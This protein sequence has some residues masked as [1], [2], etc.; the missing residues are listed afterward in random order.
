MSLEIDHVV[1]C[2]ADL[3]EAADRLEADYGLV[4]IE[5]GRHAGHGTANRIVPLG[6][7][8]LELVGVVDPEETRASSFGRWVAANASERLAPHALCLR[9]DDLDGLCDRF[10]LLPVAM[11]RKKP[12]GTQLSWRVAGLE[13]AF[14]EGLPFFIEWD[15]DPADHPGRAALLQATT[16]PTIVEVSLSGDIGRLADWV[17]GTDGVTLRDGKPGL[18]SVV[19]RTDGGAL[20]F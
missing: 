10:G 15:I 7:S 5:G 17:G 16:E 1:L 8:Y 14:R 11:T 2:V 6:A 19:V 4:S 20:T 3:G 13:L 9:T 18:D 12:E